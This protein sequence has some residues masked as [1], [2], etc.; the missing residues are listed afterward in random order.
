MHPYWATLVS[1]QTIPDV[2]KTVF[3]VDAV[4][5]IGADE[6][7]VPSSVAAAMRDAKHLS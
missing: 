7:K 1:R 4:A 3:D 5:V 6:K 2:Q